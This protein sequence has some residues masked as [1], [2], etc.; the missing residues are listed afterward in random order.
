LDTGLLHLHHLLVVLYSLQLIAKVALVVARKP[1]ALARFTGLLRIPHLILAGLMLATGLYL[2]LRAPDGFAAWSLVKYAV[3]V[4]AIGL[5][6]LAVRQHSVAA[7][8]LS[9]GL[10]AYAYAISHD[11]DAKLRS[12]GRQFDDAWAAAAPTTLARGQAIYEAGCRRCHGSDGKAGYRKSK[13]LT[14]LRD[15]TAIAAI[16]RAGVLG[17]AMPAYPQAQ[18]SDEQLG[19]LIV[20]VREGLS[21]PK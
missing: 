18:L 2:A 12:Q 13:D 17:K 15:S 8:V 9:V 19:A 1:D 7:G 3:L 10:I 6:L 14:Q 21:A 11:H 16:V 20:Y 5:G 4:G